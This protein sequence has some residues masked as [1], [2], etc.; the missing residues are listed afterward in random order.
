MK[1]AYEELFEGEFIHTINA[2]FTHLRAQNNLIVDIE[3]ST[4]P[5]LTMRWVIMGVVCD[6]LLQKQLRLFKHF[7]SADKY[8]KHA[9]P[10][11]S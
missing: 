9:L 1:H 3:Q 10:I 11:S 4:C 8:Q 5:K 7:E 6:W 2:V